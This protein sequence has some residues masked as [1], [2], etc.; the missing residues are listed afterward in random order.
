MK[1]NDLTDLSLSD[2]PTFDDLPSLEDFP[3]PDDLVERAKGA[4]T[5]V[6]KVPVDTGT[7]LKWTLVGAG[8][9]AA[10]WLAYRGYRRWRND[11]QDV[12]PEQLRSVA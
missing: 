4:V 12:T 7:L 9:A 2:L 3:M 8:T 10:G 6:R 1:L 11:D 5:V